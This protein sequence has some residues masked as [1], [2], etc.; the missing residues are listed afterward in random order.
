MSIMTGTP[1]M[2]NIFPI[3]NSTI[4][5]CTGAA[6]ALSPPFGGFIRMAGFLQNRNS[7]PLFIGNSSKLPAITFVGIGSDIW[8]GMRNLTIG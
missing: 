1:N 2:A 3:L 7:L 6:N 5:M 4:K 8:G